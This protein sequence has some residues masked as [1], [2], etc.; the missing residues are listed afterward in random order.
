MNRRTAWGLFLLGWGLGGLF[1]LAVIN[2]AASYRPM[3]RL[4]AQ[5]CQGSSGDLWAMEESDFPTP[6]EHIERY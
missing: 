4:I 6:C 1:V 2:A 3:P 5:G